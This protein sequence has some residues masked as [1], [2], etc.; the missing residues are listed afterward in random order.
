MQSTI[1]SRILVYH[2]QPYEPVHLEA[3]V[4]V[5]VGFMAW[6]VAEGFALIR[7]ATIAVGLGPATA[8]AVV[9]GFATAP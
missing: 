3:D 6:K 9:I 8:E 1:V 2:I 7:S 5:P 4:A